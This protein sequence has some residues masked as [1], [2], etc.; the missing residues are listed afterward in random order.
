MEFLTWF[1]VEARFFVVQSLSHSQLFATSWTASCQAPLSMEFSKQEYWS[2]LPVPS[3]GNLPNP[4]I[5]PGSL[6]LQAD[7]LPS[8]PLGKKKVT[9]D[10]L[11]NS[12]LLRFNY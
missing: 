9:N 7:S 3:P 1:L 12:Y 4:G 8:E 6:A 10:L 2:G 11:F 5:R